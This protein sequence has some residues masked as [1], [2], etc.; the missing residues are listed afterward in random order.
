M[1]FEK[2]YFYKKK[3]LIFIIQMINVLIHFVVQ[4]LIKVEC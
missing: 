2:G 3:E 4:F 1:D